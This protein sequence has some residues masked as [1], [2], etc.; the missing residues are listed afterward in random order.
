MNKKDTKLKIENSILK[1]KNKTLE[2][3]NKELQKELEFMNKI[4]DNY[5][6]AV[7]NLRIKTING[8]KI[9]IDSVSI[10]NKPDLL[11][12]LDKDIEVNDWI[13]NLN[14]PYNDNDW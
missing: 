3:K 7:S 4:F 10:S 12:Q 6:S 5:Y 14:S 9:W 1:K 11:F 2:Q 8:K 13:K